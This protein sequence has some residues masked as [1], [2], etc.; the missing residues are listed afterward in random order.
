MKGDSNRGEESDQLL[1]QNNPLCGK[2][3][4][5]RV[6]LCFALLCFALIFVCV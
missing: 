1:S 5:D 3:G 4:G 6:V 2:G